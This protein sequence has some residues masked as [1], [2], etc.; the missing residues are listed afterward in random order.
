MLDILIPKFKYDIATYP[1]IEER[2][3]D[4]EIPERYGVKTNITPV[5]I[6]TTVMK[7]KLAK[8]EIKA[9]DQIVADGVV[10]SIGD[11][12]TVDLA[13]AEFTLKITP[14]LER[15]TTYY[16]EISGDWAI[17]GTD[18]L[19]IYGWEDEYADGNV[20]HING[21]DVWDPSIDDLEFSI[22]GK[23][24]LD[25]E[26]VIKLE[27]YTGYANPESVF[28]PTKLRDHADR[29]KVG[30]KF[31]TLDE[32][33]GFFATRLKITV[34]ASIDF[35][36]DTSTI[37]VKIYSDTGSTLVGLAGTPRTCR[38]VKE[39]YSAFPFKF[40]QRGLP[41]KVLVDIQGYK[42][43]GNVM[44]NV[45]DILED[46]MVNIV[47]VPVGDLDGDAFDALRAARTESIN[48]QLDRE[49]P[50]GSFLTKLEAG[51]L[52]KF[53][54]TLGGGFSPRFYA[55]GE[56]A[57]TPH[58]RDGDFL[59]FS[60]KRNL[61]SVKRRY[62]IEYDEDATSQLYK[63]EESISAIAEYI[64]K[65]KETLSLE[66]YLKDSA[67]AV[68]L[69]IDYKGLLEYPQ[70]EIQFEVKSYLLDKIPTDKV[71]ITR[72]R[73]DNSGGTFDAVLFRILKLTKKQSTGTVICMA[74]LDT[75]TY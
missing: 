31:K 73:G 60:S 8:R 25:G 35:P 54:P 39:T 62:I 28:S 64:Y 48:P 11:D 66:T 19:R 75:Q 43:N 17:D 3:V 33:S 32:G 68:Q 20:Y 41:S 36:I 38:W 18:W 30:M 22:W 45:A 16:L 50:F 61:E 46:V 24:T 69:G 21:A 53:L 47:G 67:D 44:D 52:F 58:L 59:W 72:T 14:F 5:C 1:D 23:D 10:L 12:Y 6:D 65:N 70:R 56:P 7:Y 34:F 13:N 40:P 63:K 55:S 74:V 51:Q 15:N 4:M 27:Q 57:G 26:E 42:D 49:I 29:T 37:T 2:G 9:I 71:K